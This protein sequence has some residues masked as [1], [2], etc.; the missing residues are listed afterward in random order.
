MTRFRCGGDQGISPDFACEV[1]H[2]DE[3]ET[4]AIVGGMKDWTYEV[5]TNEVEGFVREG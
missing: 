2:F 4:V 5:K 1:F 3:Y